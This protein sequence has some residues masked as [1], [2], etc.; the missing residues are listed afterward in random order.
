MHLCIDDQSLRSIN[1]E[2]VV[3][4]QS[5]RNE[6][7]PYTVDVTPQDATPTGDKASYETKSAPKLPELSNNKLS[8]EITTALKK[9]KSKLEI[10]ANK[11]RLK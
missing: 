1:E 10:S 8:I 6:I 3:N 2:K 5:L 7:G 4:H 11:E 9:V